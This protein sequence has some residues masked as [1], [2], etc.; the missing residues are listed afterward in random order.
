MKKSYRVFNYSLISYEPVSFVWKAPLADAYAFIL[1]ENEVRRLIRSHKWYREAYFKR[2]NLTEL[3]CRI[4]L[5]C[6]L[7]IEG[8]TFE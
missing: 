7:A 2:Y 8:I 1:E 5:Q 6:V 3:Q 4:V